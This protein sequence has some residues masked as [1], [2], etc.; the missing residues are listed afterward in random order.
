M[1]K[2]YIAG[3]VTGLKPDTV[4]K[5][6]SRAEKYWESRGFI[7]ANPTKLCNK[8]WSWLRC[9]YVCLRNLAKCDFVYFM[10]NYKKSRGAK[11][12]LWFAKKLNKVIT[13]TM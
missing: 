4:R 5:N 11:I 6:F 3:R 1:E 10:P 8:K 2:I 12:E 7:V 9:M 13:F